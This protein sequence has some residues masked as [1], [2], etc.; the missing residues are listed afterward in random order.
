[1]LNDPKF[2]PSIFD[3]DE[4]DAQL[5]AYQSA[6]NSLRGFRERL[7]DKVADEMADTDSTFDNPYL[8]SSESLV[9][10]YWQ[11]M[12]GT[13]TVYGALQ[14]RYEEIMPPPP[15]PLPKPQWVTRVK[16][17]EVAAEDSTEDAINE[18]LIENPNCEIASV[19]MSFKGDQSICTVVYKTE[20]EPEDPPALDATEEFDDALGSDWDIFKN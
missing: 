12:L 7:M 8:G 16:V 15:P 2:D 13:C 14:E 17:F 4:A 19:N 1:M 6:L 10:K 5:E 20:D 11:L 3:R 9:E 18:W